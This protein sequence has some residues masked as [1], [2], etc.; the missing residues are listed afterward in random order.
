[1]QFV[2]LGVL[3]ARFRPEGLHFADGKGLIFGTVTGGKVGQGATEKVGF[4]GKTPVVRPSAIPDT[5]SAT[6]V[7]L[8]AEVNKLKALLRTVGLMA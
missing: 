8:E 5:A 4:W 1:M 2:S 6:L 7:A 3:T